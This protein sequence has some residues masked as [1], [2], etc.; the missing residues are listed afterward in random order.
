MSRDASIANDIR[1]AVLYG[2]HV[3]NRRYGKSRN[4]IVLIDNSLESNFMNGAKS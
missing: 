3:R 4:A 1:H 2:N